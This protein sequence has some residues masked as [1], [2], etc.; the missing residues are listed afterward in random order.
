MR[1]THNTFLEYRNTSSHH[2]HHHHSITTWA[3]ACACAEHGKLKCARAWCELWWWPQNMV[4]QLYFPRIMYLGILFFG[5]GDTP[6]LAAC[7]CCNAPITTF[8]QCLW[9]VV[10]CVCEVNGNGYFDLQLSLLD[11]CC[12]LLDN[13]YGDLCA[14]ATGDHEFGVETRGFHS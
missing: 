13:G 9:A 6:H 1:R 10:A 3:L 8:V 12:I 5:G 7:S 11:Q 14:V 4:A 2:H